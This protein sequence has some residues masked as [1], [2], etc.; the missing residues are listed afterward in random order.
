MLNIN[1][2]NITTPSSSSSALTMGSLN[3]AGLAGLNF[4]DVFR[5]GGA[6]PG[7]NNFTQII[8]SLLQ[9]LSANPNCVGG[10]LGGGVAPTPTPAAPTPTPTPTAPT[11]TPAAPTPV[12]PTPSPKPG[13]TIPTANNA[14]GW[15]DP[16]FIG[17]DGGRYDVQG[18]AG[19]YYNILSDD[20]FQM[21]A[22]F[23]G[24][25]NAGTTIMGEMGAVMGTDKV[26]VDKNGQLT[27][28]GNVMKDGTY[29]TE[30]G[31]SV[32]KKG[33][34]I[35]LKDE[36]YT[37]TITSKSSAGGNYLDF[38]VKSKDVA[39]DGVMPH[40]IWGQTA[41][42]DKKV[43]KGDTGTG[44]QGGGVL[45]KLDGT[46]SKRGDKQTVQ[47][48]EVGSLFDTAFTNFNRFTGDTGGD[49]VVHSGANGSGERDMA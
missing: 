12:A 32:T 35:T 42:G 16:H 23:V 1:Q 15:G 33:K 43:R 49:T 29:P 27:L 8:M 14:G 31:G 25:K 19:N 9:Q 40:G 22:K 37:V 30:N 6:V 34:V 36:E 20:G 39:A 41:D 3:S 18:K 11:P 10:Q 45:E 44:A 26:Q 46:I 5:P 7:N 28:N 47:L 48:Y 17:A 24:F 21:N 4:T 38:R 2:S 13:M